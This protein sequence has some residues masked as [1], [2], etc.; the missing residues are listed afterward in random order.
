MLSCLLGLFVLQQDFSPNA[1][2]YI[3]AQQGAKLAEQLRSNQSLTDFRYN[4]TALAEH[5]SHLLTMVKG[6]P[7]TNK[8]VQELLTNITSVVNMSVSFL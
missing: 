4:I 5:G 7:S 6:K 1:L 2:P 8:L 3:M